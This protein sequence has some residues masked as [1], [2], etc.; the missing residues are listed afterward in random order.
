MQAPMIIGKNC[1]MIEG[2]GEYIIEINILIPMIL[3]ESQPIGA[4]NKAHS[5]EYGAPPTAR[6]GQAFHLISRLIHVSCILVEIAKNEKHWICIIKILP[7]PLKFQ[8][9]R[10][11][12]AAS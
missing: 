2:C 4:C 7:R 5:Q 6:M 10:Q 8:I 1:K 12:F 3:R 9:H 11:Y